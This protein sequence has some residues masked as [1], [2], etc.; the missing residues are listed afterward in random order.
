MGV[1]GGSGATRD[2][3]SSQE[4][5]QEQMDATRLERVARIPEITGSMG[6]LSQNVGFLQ[7]V[8]GMTAF[9]PDEFGQI[10]TSADPNIGVVSTPEGERIAVNNQTGQAFSINKL[11]PSLMDAVQLGGAVAAFTPAGRGATVARQALGGVGTQAVIEGGQAALGGQINPADIAIAG[12]APVVVSAAGKAIGQGLRKITGRP[13]ATT[14]YIEQQVL[15]AVPPPTVPQ[16]AAVSVNESAK[17]A[18]IRRAIQEGSVE[19]VGWTVDDGGRIIA[20]QLQRDLVKKGVN[21]RAIVTLRDMSPADKRHARRMI[22]L[23]ESYVKGVKG[24]ERT[25]PQTVIGENAMKRFEVIKKAQQDAS[26]AIG[27]A[28]QKDIKGKPADIT[29]EFDGFLDSLDQLGIKVDGGKANFKDSLVRGSNVTP[30]RNV[31]DVLKPTYNDAG[32]LHKLKQF[33]TN[34]L[35]YD[36]P[37][38]KPLDRQAENALKALRAQVNEKLRSMSPDYAAANDSFRQ[39]A[40]VVNPF[41]KVMGRRFDPESSRVENY[42]G[43]ELRKVLTNYQK[44]DDLVIAIDD[45]DS[46]A[47]TFGGKFDDDLM[48]LIVLNSELERN[49]GSFAPGS[50]QGVMEKAGGLVADQVTGG[51][52]QTAKAVAGFA[53]DRLLFTPPSKE[54]LELIKQLKQ[55]TN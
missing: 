31:L 49:L 32:E 7:A 40:E 37:A 53:K 2:W 38:T 24:S 45:L 1:T 34:Q 29:A 18:D 46:V 5:T 6:K 14:E 30:I 55:L 47:K 11:G 42:V 8:G 20:D 26:K 41:A 15:K 22:D 23:A 12:A 25:R 52:A 44:A 10:L 36:N 4:L 28:V 51:A 43:K 27:A 19:S 17:R 39:A 13:A 50:I 48:S 3:G 35:D 33:I 16:K 9:D 21:D 54:K